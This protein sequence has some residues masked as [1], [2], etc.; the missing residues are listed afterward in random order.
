MTCLPARSLAWDP[1]WKTTSHGAHTPITKSYN[2][3]LTSVQL[4]VPKRHSPTQTPKP[5]AKSTWPDVAIRLIDVIYELL[6]ARNIIGYTLFVFTIILFIVAAR[7]PQG[8]INAA[9]SGL[10]SVGS[11]LSSEKFYIFPLGA[12]LAFSVATNCI[13]H[14]V[15]RGHINDLTQH[16]KFLVHGLQSGKLK[17]LKDHN[18][19][20]YED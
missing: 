13:Q 14:K 4:S 20:G 2:F 17:P 11:F 7:S 19:S 1:P 8:S 18:S 16:R 6:Q 3:V 12:A 10:H 15:Y 5:T 9:S